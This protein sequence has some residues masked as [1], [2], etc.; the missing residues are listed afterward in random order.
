[1]LEAD[2][3]ACFDMIDHAVLMDR[4]RHRVS[5]KHVL[6]LVKACRVPKVRHMS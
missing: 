1:M 6:A 5:D 2:I 3:E 4:V